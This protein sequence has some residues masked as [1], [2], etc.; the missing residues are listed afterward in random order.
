M[1]DTFYIKKRKRIE[2][3]M[4]I[5]TLCL[6]V[7]NFTQHKLRVVMENNNETLPNQISKQIKNP[8]LKWI[9]QLME[10]VGIVKMFDKA[11]K[12]IRSLIT[13]LNLVRKKII[14]LL[15]GLTCEIYGIPLEIAGM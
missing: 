14:R 6:L 15:G 8:T 10:G 9:F 7:Y 11:G 13:N 5:M 4:M 12:C 1:V 3:L 2:A